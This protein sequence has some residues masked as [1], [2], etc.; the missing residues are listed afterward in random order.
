LIVLVVAVS[1][2]ASAV[3]SASS[4]RAATN[5][6]PATSTHSL[7]VGTLDRSWVEVAP[8][9]P[10]PKSAPIIVVLSGVSATTSLEI[11][12]DQLV[13]FVS[14]DRA[15]LIYPVG[16]GRSWNAGGCCG[17]AGREDIDDVA[18]LQALV[19]HVDP[20]RRRPID[21]VGYS[22]GGRLAYRVAC[23]DPALFD[24]TAVVKAMPQPGCVV[25]QPLS[26]LQIVS[27]NDPHIPY[28]PGDPGTEQPSATVQVARLR[29]TDGCALTGTVSTRGSLVLKTWSQCRDHV[30][31]AF[32]TYGGGGHSWPA[33][34][35]K[36]PSAAD[37][38]WD[39]VSNSNAG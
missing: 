36:T 34:N 16:I 10:L 38:I 27:T 2:A 17:M 13:Q 23:T 32:A 22:N 12:R 25:S 24:A 37:A 6:T 39:F 9:G 30:Q 7:T 19:A 31:L 35:A 3:A 5:T 15:E 33:G 21:L 11:K 20:G 29:A 1:V 14:T 28:K 4:G 8:P 18:F 26:I